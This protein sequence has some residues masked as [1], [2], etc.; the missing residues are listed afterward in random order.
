MK[1]GRP[2]NCLDKKKRKT[3]RIFNSAE[4]RGVVQDYANGMTKPEIMVKYNISK[5]ALKKLL[6]KR[7]VSL[8]IT[9]SEIEQMQ[10]LSLKSK[11]KISGIY[12]I[13]VR[14]KISLIDTTN[15]K[16]AAIFQN[17]KIYVGSS[18]NVISRLRSHMHDLKNKKHFNRKL[19]KD[20]N[21]RKYTFKC[22]L[23]EGEINESDLLDVENKY[24]LKWN[25][26]SYYNKNKH[27]EIKTILPF[28]Q[29]AV[30][31]KG[32]TDN[33]TL[34]TENF[35][36]GTACKEPNYVNGQKGYGSLNILVNGEEKTL[37]KHRVAFWEHYGTYPKLV[38]HLCNNS[39]CYNPLHLME[40]SHRQNGLDKR[41]DFPELFEKKWLEFG[42]DVKELSDFFKDKWKQNQKYRGTKVSNAIFQWEKKLGLKEK[43]PEVLDKNKNRRFS[44][45]HRNKPKSVPRVKVKKQKTLYDEIMRNAE[46]VECPLAVSSGVATFVK[47]TYLRFSDQ[48]IFDILKERFKKLYDPVQI[49]N[50]RLYLSLY[51]N[52]SEQEK[53]RRFH[54]SIQPMAMV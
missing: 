35:Y 33:Y 9:S 50:T 39:K 6:Q 1:N 21:S 18:I 43:Y 17:P 25:T 32:Y 5:S 47:A 44:I 31:S 13:E 12:L 30:E 28:L 51:R 26:S 27:P 10:L 54:E 45:A 2:K 52:P 23:I 14:R 24:L 36:D 41:G 20:Y 22:Y 48:E 40:G 15:S 53:F 46:R 19:Q 42:A 16:D 3:R 34:S 8:R 49:F 4:E 38:R 11:N 37:L 7:N 29:K